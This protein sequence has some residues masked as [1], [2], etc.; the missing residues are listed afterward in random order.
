[1]TGKFFSKGSLDWVAKKTQ[2]TSFLPNSA[3]SV[4]EVFLSACLYFLP[5]SFRQ[6]GGTGMMLIIENTW[7]F[8]LYS[9]KLGQNVWSEVIVNVI[10]IPLHFLP[11][12]FLSCYS[13]MIQ[14][15]HAG[16]L[17][18]LLLNSDQK[19]KKCVLE[20]TLF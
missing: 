20:M 13:T 10:A 7:T 19:E 14:E 11:N 16:G 4:P 3:F 9:W 1:M 5:L 6:I 17:F 2:R 18:I 12:F 15:R 8:V